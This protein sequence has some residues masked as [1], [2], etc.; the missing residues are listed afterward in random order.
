MTS[1]TPDISRIGT[2]DEFGLVTAL[3]VLGRLHESG[4]DILDTE[5]NVVHQDVASDRDAEWLARSVWEDA[6]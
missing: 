6:R 4:W 5:G 3:D 2:V 1:T